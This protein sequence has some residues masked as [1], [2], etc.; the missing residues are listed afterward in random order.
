MTSLTSIAG[1]ARVARLI[2]QRHRHRALWL[3]AISV[4]VLVSGLLSVNLGSVEWQWQ[5]L[6][7]LASNSAPLS[8]RQTMQWYVF[9][10]LRLP[11]T[12]MAACVGALLGMAG[13]AMQ[14]LVRNPL[15]DPGLIGI[16]GGAAA[17]AAAS[18]ALPWTL[19][20]SMGTLSTTL[21][22]FMGALATVALVLHMARRPNGIA[23]ST[24]IL[25]G[26]AINALT[27]TIIGA[28]SYVASDDALRQISYWTM[29]SLAG[30]EW[31]Q[32][33]LLAGCLLISSSVFMLSR[34]ALNLFALGE[35]EAAFQGLNVKR[36]KYY[37]LWTVAFAV[38]LCTALCGIIGF[39]GLVI[40][41]ICR[42]LIGVDHRYLMPASGILGSVLLILSDCLSRSLL[43]PMEIPIGIITSAV[44][45]PFFLYL[46]LKNKEA[47]LD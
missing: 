10:D 5:T 11:R 29:G 33:C 24:L 36:Y 16:S 9:L 42:T 14:G 30:A 12:L 21:A 31:R 3:R 8:S 38:A 1:K 41:H 35:Q 28:L 2:H 43:S 20:N 7:Q 47:P 34:K 22:A 25:A 27:G 23:V 44:G 18:M 4:A 40:P 6:W 46:L 39:I 15:A 45:A 26:V 13:C 37:L 19:S 17:A 32:V